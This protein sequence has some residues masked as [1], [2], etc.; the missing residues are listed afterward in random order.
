MFSYLYHQLSS[1]HRWFIGWK[2]E[3]SKE[4]LLTKCSLL[5]PV[6]VVT[7]LKGTPASSSQ[8]PHI[9]L[10]PLGGILPQTWLAWQRQLTYLNE[11]LCSFTAFLERKAILQGTQ[12]S[13]HPLAVGAIN[14]SLATPFD[15][16][17][18]FFLP[19]PLLCVGPSW[20]I[21]CLLSSLSPTSRHTPPCL[22]FRQETLTSLLFRYS[23]ASP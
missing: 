8:R 1:F 7:T 3:R 20:I 21:F 17:C 9:P 22:L 14:V 19:A 11:L 23:L 4:K 6:I 12:T 13:P 2:E 18:L 5:P 10:C 15:K 16:R